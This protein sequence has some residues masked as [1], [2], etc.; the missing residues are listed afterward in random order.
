MTTF[1][2]RLRDAIRI[3]RETERLAQSFA[4]NPDGSRSTSLSASEARKLGFSVY[5][6]QRDGVYVSLPTEYSGPYD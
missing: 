5:D 4:R 2:E 1:A 3:E 6:S